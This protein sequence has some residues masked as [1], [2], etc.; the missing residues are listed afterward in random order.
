MNTSSIARTCA[1]VSALVTLSMLVAPAQ[2]HRCDN[3]APG[4]EAR[5]CAADAQGADALRRFV[6]R[7]RMIYGLYYFD[8]RREAPEPRADAATRVAQ[9]DTARDM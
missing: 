5:A 9:R 2:A 7:T 6:A 3:P 4:G 1:C 8:L